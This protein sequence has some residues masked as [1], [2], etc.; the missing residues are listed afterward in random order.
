L[1][2]A[3]SVLLVAGVFGIAQLRQPGEQPVRALPNDQPALI[4][5]VTNASASARPVTFV[6]HPTAGA[7]RYTL[8]L[9]ASDGTVLFST[10]TRDTTVAAAL[11]SAAGDARWWVRAHMDDGSER[12][13]ETRVLRLKQ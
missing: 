13:S 10:S 4:A 1:A 3:A 5:P 12:R 8:E 7:L 11:T 9:A 6:W 2:A